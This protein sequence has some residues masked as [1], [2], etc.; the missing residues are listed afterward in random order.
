MLLEAIAGRLK[1]LRAE[2]GVSQE[3]VYEDTGVHI[4]KIET[5]RYNITVST[6]SKL[7]NYYGITLKEFFD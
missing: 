7:C 2:K 5:A 6:L 3:T 1:E 4:G